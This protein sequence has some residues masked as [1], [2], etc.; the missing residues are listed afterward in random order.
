M[1][2]N[3]PHGTHRIQKAQTNIKFHQVISYDDENK[4]PHKT[5]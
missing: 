5:S 1:Q 2:T 4:N 3:K